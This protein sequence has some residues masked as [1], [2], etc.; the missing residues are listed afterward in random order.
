MKV[1]FNEAMNF[2]ENYAAILHN[3]SAGKISLEIRGF[4][5]DVLW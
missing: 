5:I 3:A 4:Q 2:N 1:N